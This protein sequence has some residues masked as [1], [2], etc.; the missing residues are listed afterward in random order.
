MK[1]PDTDWRPLPSISSLEDVPETA[2][3]FERFY[4]LH[5]LQ[6]RY[7][8]QKLEGRKR[9]G[10]FQR[11]SNVFTALITGVLVMAGTMIG[12]YTESMRAEDEFSLA[13][14]RLEYEVLRE[15]IEVKDA[16]ATRGQL[17]FALD[18]ELL[19]HFHNH[20]QNIVERLKNIQC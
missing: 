3:E 1:H 20:A 14:K 2:D 10:F 8:Q 18:M 19:R 4:K 12:I 9:A 5:D 16:C 13:Q 17:Q 15:S 7:H 6:L 11:H